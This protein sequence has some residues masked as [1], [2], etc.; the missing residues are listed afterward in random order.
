[1]VSQLQK[2]AIMAG[3]GNILCRFKAPKGRAVFKS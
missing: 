2:V 3:V 1:M